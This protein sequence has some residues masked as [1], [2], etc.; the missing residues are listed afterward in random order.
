LTPKR[1]LNSNSLAVIL[2]GFPAE[3]MAAFLQWSRSA[4][5]RP[6]PLMASLLAKAVTSPVKGKRARISCLVVI[7][8]RQEWKMSQSYR[9]RLQDMQV[10]LETDCW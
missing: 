9:I 7:I 5:V 10:S 1:R 3:E 8:V 6:A 4:N 2:S